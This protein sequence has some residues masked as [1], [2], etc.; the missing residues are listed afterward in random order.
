M[1]IDDAFIWYFVR[2]YDGLRTSQF[3]NLW[4]YYMT[5]ERL[6]GPIDM[7]RLRN[8]RLEDNTVLWERCRYLLANAYQQ[9]RLRP[10][11]SSLSEREVRLALTKS[12]DNACKA[13]C[14]FSER[15]YR[16]TDYRYVL[17][18]C[19]GMKEMGRLMYSDFQSIPDP[20]DGP[21]HT[22]RLGYT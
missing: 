1:F 19:I 12:L 5:K 14:V 7:T 22:T 6:A 18:D 4:N 9:T 20:P 10:E 15:Q 3:L 13:T 17:E 11:N 16:W 21:A 8:G 2:N